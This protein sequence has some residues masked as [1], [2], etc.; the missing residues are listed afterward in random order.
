MSLWLVNMSS[1]NVVY[2]ALFTYFEFISIVPKGFSLWV[3]DIVECDDAKMEYMVS[4]WWDE[5]RS[6]GIQYEICEKIRLEK[7]IHF[8]VEVGCMW[9]N[10]I[11]FFLQF[12]SFFSVFFSSFAL[13]IYFHWR[14]SLDIFLSFFTSLF[15]FLVDLLFYIINTLQMCDAAMFSTTLPTRIFLPSLE[16]LRK[17]VF[18]TYIYPQ[19][20]IYYSCTLYLMYKTDYVPTQWD[21]WTSVTSIH[22]HI[23]TVWCGIKWSVRIFLVRE[24]LWWWF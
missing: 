8:D 23:Y 1:Q 11:S 22:I 10:L 4:D 6:I 15:F 13:L 24:M 5:I 14:H 12:S 17:G 19:Y 2:C 7:K 21:Y 9:W 20:S 16:Y 18:L 3:Y